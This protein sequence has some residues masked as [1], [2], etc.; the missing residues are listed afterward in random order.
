M[1]R[2]GRGRVLINAQIAGP[3]FALPAS[4]GVQKN[5]LAQVD[6]ELARLLNRRLQ[7]QE[8]VS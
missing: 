8:G 4:R 6:K 7:E 3:L 2:R 1:T 5:A